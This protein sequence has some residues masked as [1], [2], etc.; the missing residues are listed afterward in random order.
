MKTVKILLGGIAGGI[1]YFF[2]GW[3]IYGIILFDYMQGV[4]NTCASRPDEEMIWWALI[5]SNL[6]MG[7]LLA[8]VFDLPNIKKIMKGIWV[9]G[10]IGGMLAISIDLSFYSMSTVY[11]EFFPVIADIIAYF[12]MS[13]ITGAIICLVMKLV[14]K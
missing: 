11:Y 2:L 9:G 1:A 6:A 14:K 7:F 3:L 5:V 10:I 12:V 13:A 4:M 8:I